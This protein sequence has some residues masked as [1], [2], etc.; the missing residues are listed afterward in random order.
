MLKNMASFVVVVIL[1]LFFTLLLLLLV[2]LSLLMMIAGAD[3][4]SMNAII[5]SAD[6][7][8]S[9]SSI[10]PHT[11]LLLGAQKAGT[12][13]LASAIAQCPCE[14]T[15]V[16]IQ[17]PVVGKEAHIFDEAEEEEDDDDKIDWL[18][19]WNDAFDDDKYD[20]DSCDA[21]CPHRWRLD[22]TPA[23]LRLPMRSAHRA[24]RAFRKAQQPPRALVVTLRDPVARA[25]SSFH[26]H[27]E[28]LLLGSGAYWTTLNQLLDAELVA[29]KACAASSSSWNVTDTYARCAATA[30]SP[31]SPDSTRP[32]QLIAAGWYAPQV[33]LWRRA[34]PNVTFI[35][36]T[37]SA[38][39]KRGACAVASKIMHAVVIR[40]DIVDDDNKNN[41][42]DNLCGCQQITTP[43]PQTTTRTQRAGSPPPALLAKLRRIFKNHKQANEQM[44]TTLRHHDDNAIVIDDDH[45]DDAT[46]KEKK[47]DE[48]Y[49]PRC[50]PLLGVGAPGKRLCM[51]QPA[52]GRMATI[53]DD[54]GATPCATL[55]S[56]RRMCWPNVL[57]PGM[58]RAGTTALH[59]LLAQHPQVRT[60]INGGK[61][62]YFLGDGGPIAGTSISPD[63]QRAP[64]PLYARGVADWADGF[65][66]DVA[67]GEIVLDVSPGD[68]YG[69]HV[70]GQPDVTAAMRAHS[71]LPWARV[72][73]MLREPVAR[74]WSALLYYVP[75]RGD[76]RHV[77][78]EEEEAVGPQR[79]FDLWA[80]TGVL[81]KRID[82]SLRDEVEEQQD[83]LL[84][85]KDK[86]NGGGSGS[87]EEDIDA[88]HPALA[89]MDTVWVRAWRDAFGPE[90]VMVV[91]QEDLWAEPE[92]VRNQIH[93]FLN[94]K[95][96]GLWSS[97]DREHINHHDHSHL[98][99]WP[100]TV[101]RLR[102]KW[103]GCVHELARE[104]GDVVNWTRWKEV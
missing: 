100:S 9:S 46:K 61:G 98:K 6:N 39:R 19:R 97:S 13:V 45:L 12:T 101:R 64:R 54:N 87:C 88:A 17:T 89:F 79:A 63:Y 96:F 91:L 18:A 47:N 73:L 94:L 103:R 36:V 62:R 21:T 3:A 31:K 52:D 59:A 90:R 1:P 34:F 85:E 16:R 24:A 11:L 102:Q 74:A 5:S 60:G 77:G 58:K 65:P 81:P 51:S 14:A 37:E 76:H 42:D 50:Q 68:V 75:R 48:E 93:K 104:V 72:I 95:T 32:L 38:M 66:T 69:G 22:A 44:I 53:L 55:P 43:M 83:E 8:H 57:V 2:V 86:N 25:L 29:W 15:G 78:E 28:H 40:D 23:Y 80:R 71:L 92:A 35:V 84:P 70:H 41:N 49:A 67:V 27:Y 7:H 82:L 26:H 56:G 20:E 30:S 10:I 99:P 4:E 33:A